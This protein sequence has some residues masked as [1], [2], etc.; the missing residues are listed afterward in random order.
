[1]QNVLDECS[2]MS[3]PAGEIMND[4]Q[5]YAPAGPDENVL[6]YGLNVF[7]RLHPKFDHS[8]SMVWAGSYALDIGKAPRSSRLLRAACGWRDRGGWGLA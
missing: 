4:S 6:P 7:R 1:M 8:D 2:H 5:R 3:A